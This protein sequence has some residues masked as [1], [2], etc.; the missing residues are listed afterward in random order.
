MATGQSTTGGTP[1]VGRRRRL[2]YLLLATVAV[3]AVPPAPAVP[4][5]SVQIDDR[6]ADRRDHVT[7]APTVDE[8]GPSIE[9]S[10]EPAI[11]LVP[12]GLEE[13]RGGPPPRE[14]AA[15]PLSGVSPFQL[16]PRPPPT[17]SHS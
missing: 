4:A 11:P 3:V 16:E 17:R 15:H 9:V 1:A 7:A 13:A 2:L 12:A 10:S 14:G 5:R 8:Q 6:T